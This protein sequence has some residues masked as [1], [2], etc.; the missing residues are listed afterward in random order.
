MSGSTERGEADDRLSKRRA[1]S[2]VRLTIGE[3]SVS[4]PDRLLQTPTVSGFLATLYGVLG[5]LILL[6]VTTIE[7]P[8]AL[9]AIAGVTVTIAIAFLQRGTPS[10]TAI[11]S[12]ILPLSPVALLLALFLVSR[13]LPTPTAGIPAFALVVLTTCGLYGATGVLVG[14][15]GPEATKRA[16]ESIAVIVGSTLFALA[17]LGLRLFEVTAPS[18]DGLDPVVEAGTTVVFATGVPATPDTFGQ[19]MAVLCLLTACTALVLRSGVGR[20]PIVELAPGDRREQFEEGRSEVRRVLSRI[21]RWSLASVVVFTTFAIAQYERDLLTAVPFDLSIAYALSVSTTLRRLLV[22]V[23]LVSVL[24]I[25]VVST[26]RFV[27]RSSVPQRRGTVLPHL[28]GGFVLV[29]VGTIIH[30]RYA[31][32]LFSYVAD[33]SLVEVYRSEVTGDVGHAVVLG[34]LVLT[35]IGFAIALAV[36]LFASA[37]GLY[38]DRAASGTIAAASLL[39]CGIVLVILGTPF[40]WVLA[41]IALGVLI[42]DTATFGVRLFE[43]VGRGSGSVSLELSH[44]LAS[45]SVAVVGIAATL[46][47]ARILGPASEAG[48]PAV[49]V[50]VA[51]GVIGTILLIALLEG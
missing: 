18:L 13:G 31:L 27:I 15:V 50:A 35:L 20:I 4:E 23:S 38:R 40:V 39:G 19:N 3:S 10:S 8:I 1:S 11:G 34:S 24:T 16:L 33:E 9:A 29:A 17:V 28:A 48:S 41:V 42:W 7:T 21:L 32:T 43:E 12:A 37:L 22:W 30:D 5:G 25:I 44:A 26:L 45:V 2:K 51:G 46:L 49:V 6:A 47:G 14:S 36:L